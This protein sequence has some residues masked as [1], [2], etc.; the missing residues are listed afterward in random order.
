MPDAAAN[1]L[2]V[3]SRLTATDAAVADHP[4]AANP[5][6]AVFAEAGAR[7]D[8]ALA[9][10]DLAPYRGWIKYL[11]FEAETAVGR[12]GATSKEA[13]EKI[14]RLDESV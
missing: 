8:A 12:H 14:R 2:L 13:A 10:A 7:A 9:R 6:P 4:G 5:T 11:R 3:N 1:L